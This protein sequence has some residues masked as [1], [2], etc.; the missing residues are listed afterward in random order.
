MTLRMRGDGRW[1]DLDDEPAVQVSVRALVPAPRGGGGPQEARTWAM[2][3]LQ[4]A[5]EISAGLRP[6]AQVARWVDDAVYA[7]LA[8]RASV[9]QRV[10]GLPRQGRGAADVPG[11][12]SRRAPLVRSVHTSSPRPGVVEVA[13]VAQ[14][15]PR[16]RALACRLEDHDG[17]WRATALEFG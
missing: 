5:L 13:A 14:V 10:G 12:A 15:G 1:R 4:A 3:F 6:V 8:R 7:Q 17:Q 9:V 16:V 2:Q 11:A